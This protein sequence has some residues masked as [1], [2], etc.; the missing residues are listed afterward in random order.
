MLHDLSIDSWQCGLR[1]GME[2]IL[3]DR[4]EGALLFL[5]FLVCCLCSFLLFLVPCRIGWFGGVLVPLLQEPGVL[6]QRRRARA[7]EDCGFEKVLSASTPALTTQS[8]VV[9]CMKN[10]E[11]RGV[12]L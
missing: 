5:F 1:A 12:N 2:S 11:I 8:L 3:A 6:L 10:P 7:R 4:V 9:P